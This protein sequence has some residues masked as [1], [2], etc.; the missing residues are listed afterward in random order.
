MIFVKF[1]SLEVA[2]PSPTNGKEKNQRENAR[3]K[4]ERIRGCMHAHDSRHM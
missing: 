4:Y 1:L 2:R 3:E